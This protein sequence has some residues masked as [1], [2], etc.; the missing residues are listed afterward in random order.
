MQDM[1]NAL[2]LAATGGHVHVLRYL[3]PIFGDNKYDF[4]GSAQ[5]CLHRAA[6]EGH[7]AAV[8]YLIREHGFDPQL[9]DSVSHFCSNKLRMY[10]STIDLCT[11]PLWISL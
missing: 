9:R 1:S 2:H 7:T 10:T 8:N 5:N 4:D 6:K 11:S 3:L